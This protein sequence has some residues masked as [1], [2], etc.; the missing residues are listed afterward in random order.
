V[1][2]SH[3]DFLSSRYA[4]I[5]LDD[6]AA[7]I[8]GAISIQR[9]SVVIT[10][11][12]GYRDNYRYAYPILKN[13]GATATFFVVTDAIGNT[14]PLWSS[15][16]RDIVYRT[17]RRQVTLHS[18]D[19]APMDLSDEAAKAQVIQAIARVMRRAP[20]NGRRE[21]LREMREKLTGDTDGFLPT[22]MMSWDD[23]RE[24]RRNGMCIGSH[25]MSHPALPEIAGDEAAIE[26][27]GSKNRLEQELNTPIAHFAYP[28]PGEAVHVNEAVKELVRNAGYTT[29]RTSSKG[30]VAESSDRFQLNGISTSNKCNHP[31]L[32]AWMLNEG[33][34]RVRGSLRKFRETSH[35]N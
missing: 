27:A 10:F 5:S 16:L 23:L 29:A 32:M 8:I 31:A 3:V 12:D 14:E 28:N 19:S 35:S 30:S 26:I 6:V 4:I 34:E 18:I 24:M 21:I 22:V 13:Y 17:R 2:E 25:T 15:E 1:F 11:D 7:W 20:R 33:V 9:P